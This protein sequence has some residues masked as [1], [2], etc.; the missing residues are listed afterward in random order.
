[1]LKNFYAVSCQ[2]P[3]KFALEFLTS[4]EHF[5]FYK[6]W[7][8][9]FLKKSTPITEFTVF[10][11]T[12]SGIPH[13]HHYLPTWGFAQ[14]TLWPSISNQEEWDGKEDFFE[15]CGVL[16]LC[17]CSIHTVFFVTLGS[18][19]QPTLPLGLEHEIG[20]C[21]FRGAEPRLA[22]GCPRLLHLC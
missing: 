4:L 17:F 5:N 16:S 11:P 19:P 3:N 10:S 12:S 6:Y 18:S 8:D 20:K 9:I 15:V 2:E 1:M 14:V 13:P 21:E 22:G 7:K